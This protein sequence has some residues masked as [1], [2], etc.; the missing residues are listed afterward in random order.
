MCRKVASL[1]L[2][3]GLCRTSI[4][5]LVEPCRTNMP[6]QTC[7]RRIWCVFFI[8]VFLLLIFYAFFETSAKRN[9]MTAVFENKSVLPTC[10]KSRTIKCVIFLLILSPVGSVHECRAY[11]ICH[12]PYILILSNKFKVGQAVHCD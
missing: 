10:C 4:H 1:D 8:S 6:S 11:S 12:T 9:F 3:A 2:K 5:S 7:L